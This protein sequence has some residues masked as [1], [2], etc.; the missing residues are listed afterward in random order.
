MGILLAFDYIFVCQQADIDHEDVWGLKRVDP[1]AHGFSDVLA[2]VGM[3]FFVD[4]L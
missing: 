1:A 4:F 3:G 2:I